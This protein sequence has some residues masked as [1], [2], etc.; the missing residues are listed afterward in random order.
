MCVM[1]NAG[2]AV[3]HDSVRSSEG[4]WLSPRPFPGRRSTIGPVN[5]DAR[6]DLG[7]RSIDARGLG[8][9]PVPGLR[10]VREAPLKLASPLFGHCL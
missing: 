6:E 4:R 7:S 9:S 8:E 10:N 2:W 1:S 5:G 3:G